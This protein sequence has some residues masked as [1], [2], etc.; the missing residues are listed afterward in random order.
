MGAT[1]TS[2]MRLLRVRIL[3][4]LAVIA[5]ALPG[6]ASSRA[7]YFCRMME[8]VMPSCCCGGERQSQR[9]ERATVVRAA[10]CC[11]RIAPSSHAGTA[12]V[13]DA[14]A[15][16]ETWALVAT[17]PEIARVAF[18]SSWTDVP[19]PRAQ[20]PPGVGPPL[21]LKHCVLLT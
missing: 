3:A 15:P 2:Q 9:L 4:L 12:A 17:L 7:Q 1:L 6:G 19:V 20:A 11:E 13:R 16:I 10:D 14:S 8:R 5:M 21:F 18:N